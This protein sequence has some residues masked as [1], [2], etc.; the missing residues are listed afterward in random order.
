MITTV[1]MNPS[2]DRTVQLTSALEPGNVHRVDADTTQPGGKGINVSLGV[3][4]AGRETRALFPSD[5]S[6]PLRELVEAAATE[7]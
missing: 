7:H 6:D 2:L 3:H 1:T 5:A 4:R